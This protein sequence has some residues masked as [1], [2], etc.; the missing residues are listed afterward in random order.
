MTTNGRD[1]IITRTH[2]VN[3]NSFLVAMQEEE[4]RNRK[5][6]HTIETIGWLAVTPGIHTGTTN[7]MESIIGNGLSHARKDVTFNTS[8][9]NPPKVLAKI[10]STIGTDPCNIR[11]I[12]INSARFV[13]FIQ[14]D[15]SHD[16]EKR[17]LP[18]KFNYI[19]IGN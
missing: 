18:E 3:S 2:N 9:T 5:T 4:I 6:P 13:L 10:S 1:P 15:T 16:K 19:A 8:F 14:E 11:I 12:N 7:T 17:H